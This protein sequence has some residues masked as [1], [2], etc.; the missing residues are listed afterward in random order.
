MIS[1][2]IVYFVNA[3]VLI[4]I[5]N[6]NLSETFFGS[7]FTDIPFIGTY[8][9]SG[10]FNDFTRKWYV[11]VGGS[12]VTILFVNMIIPPVTGYIFYILKKLKRCCSWR[13]AVIQ[14]DLNKIY[15]GP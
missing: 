2:F 13:K 7:F 5:I 12:V 10:R 6:G 8:I 11:N 15:K 1:I 3:G 9:F 4:L 14:A